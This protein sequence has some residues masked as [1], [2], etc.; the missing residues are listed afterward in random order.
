MT[1]SPIT[2]TPTGRTRIR[3]DWR[4]RCVVQVEIKFSTA[5]GELITGWRNAR[6]EDIIPEIKLEVKP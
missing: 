2:E 4:G 3:Q 1:K 6:V 5:A